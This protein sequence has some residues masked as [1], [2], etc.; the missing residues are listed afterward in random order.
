MND[1]TPSPELL[2]RLSG[3]M[4]FIAWYYIVTGALACL[5]IVGALVGIPQLISGLRLKDSADE[6][7]RYAYEPNSQRLEQAL[8]LQQKFFFIQKV[9]AIVTIAFLALYFL[10]LLAIFGSG[11]RD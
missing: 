10:L 9:L 6:L 4:T 1:A 2:R 5:T 3:D 8:N 7:M 11:L